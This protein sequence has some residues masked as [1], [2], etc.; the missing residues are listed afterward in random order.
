MMLI[1]DAPDHAHSVFVEDDGRVAYAYLRHG[2]EIIGD[3][4]LYNRCETPAEPEWADRSLLPFANPATYAHGNDKGPVIHDDDVEVRWRLEEGLSAL[5][6]L[7]GLDW[8]VL[9]PGTKPG[10][11]RLAKKNGPLAK[12][13]SEIS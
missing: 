3:I 8:A 7:H 6:R 10:W 5:V 4:W 12:R 9:R 13:L 2:T 11:C 1:F